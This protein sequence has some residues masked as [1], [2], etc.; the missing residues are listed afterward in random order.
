MRAKSNRESSTLAERCIKEFGL[1]AASSHWPVGGDWIEDRVHVEA[2]AVLAAAFRAGIY[3]PL[4]VDGD[5]YGNGYGN[6]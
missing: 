2:E 1:H 4:I 3:A 6:G 5:G